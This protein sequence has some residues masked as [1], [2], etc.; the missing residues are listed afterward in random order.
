ML[1]ND[2]YLD[3]D[4]V[5]FLNAHDPYRILDRLDRLRRESGKTGKTPTKLERE[6]FVTFLDN[7]AGRTDAKKDNA[8]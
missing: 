6:A 7:F 5:G 4:L 3:L 8:A 1:W 2:L